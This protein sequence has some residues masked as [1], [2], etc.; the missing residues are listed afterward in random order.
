MGVSFETIN[1]D[2]VN[3]GAVLLE[4]LKQATGQKTVPYIF[5][6]GKLIGGRINS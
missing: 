5:I 1:V 3:D 2:T 4:A 6:G